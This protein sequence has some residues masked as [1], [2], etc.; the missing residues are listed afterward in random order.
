MELGELL[1][2][3]KDPTEFITHFCDLKAMYNLLNLISS[4]LLI[5][6]LNLLKLYNFIIDA[7]LS[8]K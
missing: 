6:I 4:E 5:H 8:T 3:F 2:T 1:Y 7:L